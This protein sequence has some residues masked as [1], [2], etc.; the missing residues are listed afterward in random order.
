MGWAGLNGLRR[1]RAYRG[2]TGLPGR[3]LA[4]Y[5]LGHCVTMIHRTDQVQPSRRA[6]AAG[7]CSMPRLGPLRTEPVSDLAPAG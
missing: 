7:G 3:A 4:G 6:S 5:A 1:L 2:V